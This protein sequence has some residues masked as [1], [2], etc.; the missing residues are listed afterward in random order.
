MS[1][2][3][4]CK[5]I[6]SLVFNVN[7]KVSKEKDSLKIY[8]GLENIHSNSTKITV[9]SNA[10]DSISTNNVFKKN[11]I[12]FGKLRPQLRKCVQPNFDGYCSTDIIVLRANIEVDPYF[13]FKILQSDRVFS[14]A[15][16]LEEGTKMPRCSWK[17]IKDIIIF[18]PPLYEQR[19]I[20]KILTTVDNL[21]EKT[22]TLI[23]KYQSIKQGMMH[24]L[25]T[26]GVDANGQLRPPVDEAPELYKESEL[27]WIP[28]E[29]EVKMIQEIAE[30]KGGKRMPAGQS[31][32][33]T[34]TPY[35]YI[36]VSDMKNWS[37]DS[38]DI[39]YVPKE[40]EP[41]ICN[42]KISKKDLYI[43]IAGVYLGLVGTIPES[44]DNAQLTENAAK[45]IIKEK[46][47]HSKE[48]LVAF[49]NSFYFESQLEQAKGIGAGVPKLALHRIE[50]FNVVLSPI[51]EQIKISSMIYCLKNRILGEKEYL[52]KLKVLKKALMQD[53][54]TGKVRVKPDKPKDTPS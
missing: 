24:D 47:A 18:H 51:K 19:K 12:L 20:A 3:L 54:L 50:K 35:P 39:V 9:T 25:F 46:N 52:L 22:E 6:C 10:S 21:I 15:I 29:W 2:N 41:L 37:V 44:L 42:Y 28:R 38:T 17:T 5:S 45:I 26:R 23:A 43:S 48:Y 33:E 27:G 30:V 8:I 49:F 34:P 14:R 53:L 32:S 40:I 11:D 1:D 31:F 16:Q 13:A 7:E 36:R 4:L